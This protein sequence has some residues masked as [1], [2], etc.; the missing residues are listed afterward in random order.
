MKRIFTLITPE[1]REVVIGAFTSEGRASAAAKRK[2]P[3]DWLSLCAYPLEQRA[4]EG[5]EK[6]IPWQRWEGN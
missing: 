3:A 2:F 4:V 6:V 5:G 1:G